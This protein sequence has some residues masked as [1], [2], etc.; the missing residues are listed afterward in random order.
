MCV[1]ANGHL[2][3]INVTSLTP[4]LPWLMNIQTPI[5]GILNRLKACDKATIFYEDISSMIYDSC[6]LD[7]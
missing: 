1:L 3:Y 5:L 2:F 4:P 6:W 7:R